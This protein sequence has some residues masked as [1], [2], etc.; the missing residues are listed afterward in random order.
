MSWTTRSGGGS[1]W[2]ATAAPARAFWARGWRRLSGSPGSLC[3]AGRAQLA[4]GLGGLE[5]NGSTEVREP[6][7]RG[8]GWRWMGGR[9]LVHGLLAARL[10]A[11]IGDRRLAGSAHAPARRASTPAVVDTV[12]VEGAAVGHESR[13][14]LASADGLEQGED[15][16]VWW[17]VTQHGRKRRAMRLYMSEPRWQHIQFMRLGSS[18]EVEAF[19]RALA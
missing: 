13:A 8:D 12:A 9:R 17:I 4:A 2:L 5:R 1:T 16:L 10:L 3:R 7:R 11:A 14:V 18:A 15:S 19:S 6:H